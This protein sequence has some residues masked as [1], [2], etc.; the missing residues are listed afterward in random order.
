[1][2]RNA[3]VRFIT[4]HHPARWSRPDGSFDVL[5]YCRWLDKNANAGAAP[6]RE[7]DT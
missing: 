3:D 1:M 4:T 6:M 5:G 7:D 2:A